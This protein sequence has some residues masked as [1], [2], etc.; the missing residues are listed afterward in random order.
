MSIESTRRAV[1]RYI[2]SQHT[3]LSMMADDVVFTN[4]ATGDQHRGRD[5][6]QQMLHYTYHVAFEA[7]AETR[8]L[9]VADQHAVLEADFVGKHIGDFAGVAASGKTVRVPLC[10]V[11]DLENDRIKR[12]R[13]YWEVPA[14]LQQ[15]AS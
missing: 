3:D 15:V 9:V 5:G 14:F 6:L 7:T 1:E 11:Y 8:N 2:R 4:M 10:V 13:V 12:G